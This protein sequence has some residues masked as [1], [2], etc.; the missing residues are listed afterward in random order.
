MLFVLHD[1]SAVLMMTGGRAHDGVTTDD[2]PRY[3]RW[4]GHL[5]RFWL[6]HAIVNELLMPGA[7]RLNQSILIV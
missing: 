2:M 4:S 5:T 3:L 7:S 6:A 1:D